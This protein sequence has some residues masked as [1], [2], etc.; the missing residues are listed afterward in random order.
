MAEPTREQKITDARMLLDWLE[1]HPNVPLPHEIESA[2]LNIYSLNSKD[3]AIMLAREFGTADKAYDDDF[4]RLK[5]RF[6]SLT[7][8]AIFTRREVCER[9]VIGSEVVPEQVTPAYTRDKVEWR[10]SPL[11]ESSA[12]GDVQTPTN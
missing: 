11:L 9:V 7:L 3:E 2:G 10:C 4:F 5:R 8:E 6:G 1:Q 12:D